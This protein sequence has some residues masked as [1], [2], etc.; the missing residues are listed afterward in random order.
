MVFDCFQDIMNHLLQTQA[1]TTSW[2]DDDP[3]IS[4]MISAW[5]R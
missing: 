4:Y 3:Q 1:D 5:A 2:E